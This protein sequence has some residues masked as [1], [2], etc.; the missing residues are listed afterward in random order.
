[1]DNNN[2]TSFIVVAGIIIL[3][4]FAYVTAYNL[5]PNNKESNSYYVKVENEISAKVETISI[6]D[7]K[8]NITTSGNANEYCIKPTK[9]SPESNNLCWKKIEN[10]KASMSVYRG[11]KY[12]VWIKD[13]KGIIRNSISINP[14]NEIK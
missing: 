12:Y 8:V 10:N 3:C 13:T 1:M 2:S 9:S 7:G 5:L 6:D 14:N 11:K 4:V